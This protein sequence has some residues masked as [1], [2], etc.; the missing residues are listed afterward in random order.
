MST[1]VAIRA[2]GRC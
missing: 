2:K 1:A